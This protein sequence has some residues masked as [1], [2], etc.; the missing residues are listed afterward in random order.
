MIRRP[1][2]SGLTIFAVAISIGC[3]VALVGVASGFKRAFQSLYETKNLDL[4]VVRAGQGQRLA[5]TLDISLAEKIRAIQ[6][7]RHVFPALVDVISFEEQGIYG[8][9]TQGLIMEPMV[10]AS[11]NVVEGRAL[12]L[13]D[14]KSLM[15]GAILA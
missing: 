9:V 7:V 1:V 2:R 8:V 11:F 3:V 14:T 12:S 5:S 15:L 10:A 4:I 13:R 6:G